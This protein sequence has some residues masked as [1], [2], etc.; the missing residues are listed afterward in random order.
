[1]AILVES[2]I[3]IITAAFVAIWVN[4]SFHLGGYLQEDPPEVA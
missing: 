2:V 1:M 4:D 3:I